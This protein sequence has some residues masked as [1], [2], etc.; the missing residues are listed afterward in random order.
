M[1]AADDSG[2]VEAFLEMQAAEKGAASNTLQAY[3]RDLDGFVR[4]LAGEETTLAQAEDDDVARY[5]RTLSDA[6]MAS[7]T[8][9]RQLSAIRQLFKFM[10]AE[11]LR[12]DDPA[13]SVA[14][15]AQGARPAQD[16]ECR[17]GRP[18]DRGRPARVPGAHGRERVRALRLHA[19]L[20]VLY[21]TGMRVSEL[22]TLPRSFWRAI[23]GF[24]PSW[25]RAGA[26][27]WC[28]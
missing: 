19:L 12:D 22:V 18:L 15:T 3:R 25:A 7:S 5:L 8:R 26:S 10:V 6:G 1:S 16:P 21:A 23:R 2:I 14:A 11:G 27:D 4:H 13:L 20:E 9:A 28:R 17:G 24:S